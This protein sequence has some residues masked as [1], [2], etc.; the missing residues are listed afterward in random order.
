MS[1]SA[2]N[3]MLDRVV[4]AALGVIRRLHHTGLA[5]TAQTVDVRV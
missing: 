1:A 4:D 3:A 5:Y 2:T